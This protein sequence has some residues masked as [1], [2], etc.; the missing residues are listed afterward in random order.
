MKDCDS[1]PLNKSKDFTTSHRWYFKLGTPHFEIGGGLYTPFEVTESSPFRAI[2]VQDETVLGFTRE[3]KD[4]LLNM[5]FYNVL[6]Q[7]LLII[8]KGEVLLSSNN[9]D[10]RF[11]G[12]AL[13]VIPPFG[14]KPIVI[15]KLETGIRISSGI[16]LERVAPWPPPATTVARGAP[17]GRRA[18]RLRGRV[19]G[20]AA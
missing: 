11:E 19:H 16:F 17:R 5:R 2:V 1:Q 9:I 13:T 4:L 6:R 15:K 7:P 3:G 8:E 12:E 14:W 10:I 20:R 18:R